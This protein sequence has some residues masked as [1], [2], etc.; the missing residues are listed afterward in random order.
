M[1]KEKYGLKCLPSGQNGLIQGNS[2]E[3]TGRPEHANV[4]D[5][6]NNL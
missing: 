2:D 4:H 6:T 5:H 1:C 3:F